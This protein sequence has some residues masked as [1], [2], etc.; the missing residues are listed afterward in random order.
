MMS[1]SQLSHDVSHMS[2]VTVTWSQWNII[3]T[4]RMII[5][6]NIFNIY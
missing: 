2:H 1:W 5:S 4:S 3:E 6:Y